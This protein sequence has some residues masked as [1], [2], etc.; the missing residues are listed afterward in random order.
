MNLIYGEIVDLV[1]KDK[2]NMARVRVGG[3]IQRVAIDLLSDVQRGDQVLICDGVA[4]GKVEEVTNVSGD[5][6]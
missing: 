3:A 1:R 2:M 5:S 4:I 6:G